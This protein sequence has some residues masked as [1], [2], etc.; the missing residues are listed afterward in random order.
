M[1]VGPYSQD[2]LTRIYNVH[3]AEGLS[4][5]VLSLGFSARP[6]GIYIDSTPTIATLSVQGLPLLDPSTFKVNAVEGT[7]PSFPPWY[8]GRTELTMP[9]G[10]SGTLKANWSLRQLPVVGTVSGQVTYDSSTTPPQKPFLGENTIQI[11]VAMNLRPTVAFADNYYEWQA[12]A[13]AIIPGLF[14]NPMA[15]SGR[16]APEET[17]TFTLDV[18][19]DPPSATFSAGGT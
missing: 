7:H 11:K 2:V 8:G 3:W 1:P 12:I 13:T 6:L 18:I 19:I 5:A 10:E 4:L 16:A 9:V 17:L 14:N 15:K